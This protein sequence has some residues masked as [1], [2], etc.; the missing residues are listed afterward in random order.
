MT[1]GV[2]FISNLSTLL[3]NTI[4]TKSYAFLQDFMLALQIFAIRMKV[5][6][7]TKVL[8]TKVS[9]ILPMLR[10]LCLLL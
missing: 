3:T 9:A 6:R 2:T 1:T 8:D 7:Y 10:I 5:L 4:I